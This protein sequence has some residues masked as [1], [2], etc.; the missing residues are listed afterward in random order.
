MS[1]VPR[2]VRLSSPKRVG[3]LADAKLLVEE[4]QK[5]A[6]QARLMR[7]GGEEVLRNDIHA[8]EYTNDRIYHQ[9]NLL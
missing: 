9:M 4:Q 8:A 6:A 2:D 5:Q 3:Q 7:K 1:E